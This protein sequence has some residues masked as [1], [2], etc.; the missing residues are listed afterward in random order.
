MEDSERS[1]KGIEDH[2]DINNKE[3]MGKTVDNILRKRQCSPDGE[4]SGK[5]KNQRTQ[6]DFYFLIVRKAAQHV[7]H[8]F[9]HA[10]GLERDAR[11]DHNTFLEFMVKNANKN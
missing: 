5:K 2:T 9:T 6:R 7:R 4:K 3:T 10:L 8:N 1:G 11:Q